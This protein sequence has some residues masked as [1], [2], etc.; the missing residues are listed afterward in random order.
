MTTSIH[1]SEDSMNVAGLVLP[2][3]PLS[4]E[5]QMGYKVYAL[6]YQ[7]GIANVFQVRTANYGTF[8]RE[9][10][11]IYQGDFRT[12]ET[13]VKGIIIGDD[14]ALVFTGHCNMVGDVAEQPWSERLDEAPF[15]DQFRPVFKG[16]KPI[17]AIES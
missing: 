4:I 8:G 5:Q 10:K 2:G 13:L 14:K 17:V 11:R 1:P 9:A 6:V 3:V 12:A 16:Y 15:S 7:A